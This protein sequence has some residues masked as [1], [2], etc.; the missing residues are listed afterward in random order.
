MIDRQNIALRECRLFASSDLEETR[1]RIS[2]IMQPH[3]LRPVGRPGRFQAHMDFLHLP[4]SGIGTIKFGHMHVDVGH[5]ADYH[6][7]I[8]CLEGQA[9]L[10]S[11]RG[12]SVADARHGVYLAPARPFRGDFS[13]DCEQLVIRIDAATMRR[14]TGQREAV[15]NGP[16]DL[17]SP[18]L[19][20]WVRLLDTILHDAG[21]VSMLRTNPDIAAAYE[22]L[23]IRMLLSGLGFRPNDPARAPAPSGVRRAEIFIEANADRFLT[24]EDIAQAVDM[25][26]RTLLDGFRRFRQT[27]PMRYMRDIR[28]DR[29]RQKLIRPEGSANVASVALDAGFGH[30][31]R[32]AQEYAARFGEKP[33][34]TRERAKRNP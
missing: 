14:H 34:Q 6:L 3:E 28:L 10:Q 8:F 11:D 27:T 25:P 32:F 7:L 29:A 24:L 23:F 17:R 16:L 5:I 9:L 22:Q 19:Q 2:E 15:L 30:L 26:V 1:L 20:P 21:T 13:Q 4:G 33:S 31:G 12:E 18:A